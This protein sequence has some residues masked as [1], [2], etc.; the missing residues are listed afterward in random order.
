MGSRA[1]KLAAR[2]PPI[3]HPTSASHLSAQCTL[4]SVYCIGLIGCLSPARGLAEWSTYLVLFQ[5]DWD[6]STSSK[7]PFRPSR[8]YRYTQTSNVAVLS[9]NHCNLP[10]T[11]PSPA[12][13]LAISP[14]SACVPF[15]PRRRRAQLSDCP[16]PPPHGSP[17]RL[18]WPAHPSP[19]PVLPCAVSADPPQL[20]GWRRAASRSRGPGPARR[21]G[22]GGAPGPHK[23]SGH[24]PSESVPSAASPAPAP[25]AGH[26]RL[27]AGGALAQ[28]GPERLLPETGL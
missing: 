14:V 22:G 1:A 16:S 10:C 11:F 15:Q 7:R 5:D 21:W 24:N 20:S 13:S 28:Y 4:H 27:C 9:L 6:F 2:G 25:S 12:S 23:R 19:L 17:P 18:M 8:S 26:P 3:R